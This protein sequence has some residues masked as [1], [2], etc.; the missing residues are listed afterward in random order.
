[1]PHAKAYNEAM[2]DLAAAQKRI[3]ELEA[4]NA[5][6]LAFVDKLRTVGTQKIRDLRGRNSELRGALEAMS[7]WLRGCPRTD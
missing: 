5:E 7:M 2:E 6:L 3:R 1:M 4:R